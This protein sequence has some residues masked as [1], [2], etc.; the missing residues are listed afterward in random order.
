[1]KNETIIERTTP[2]NYSNARRT[3]LI[4]SIGM[5]A[6]LLVLELVSGPNFIGL[7]FL[8]YLVLAIPFW[9]GIQKLKENTK[10]NKRFFQKGISYAAVAAGTAALIMVVAYAATIPF[11]G[12][13]FAT[14]T[15]N[16]TELHTTTSNMLIPFVS[17]MMLFMEVF[18]MAMITSFAILLFKYDHAATV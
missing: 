14:I 9:I 7:K 17:G 10:F 4:A 5:I 13:N 16:M 12:I 11:E 3:G 2:V 6:F 1:M 15:G 18:V 8:K